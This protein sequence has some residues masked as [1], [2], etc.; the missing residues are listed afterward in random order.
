MSTPERSLGDGA[1]GDINEPDP[2][3]DPAAEPADP[4]AE[5]APKAAPEP[6]QSTPSEPAP[7]ALDAV[8]KEKT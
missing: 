3:A 7:A 5:P 4:Q 1:S 2:H 6:E 8:K